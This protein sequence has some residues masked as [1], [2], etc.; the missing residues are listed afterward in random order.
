M[1]KEITLVNRW[2]TKHEAWWRPFGAGYTRN[3]AE[4]GLF[5]AD[6]ALG[7]FSPTVPVPLDQEPPTS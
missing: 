3:R 5:D 7:P 6:A 2:S 4:A 1:R